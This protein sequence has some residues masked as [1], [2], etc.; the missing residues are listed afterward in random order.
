MKEMEVPVQ[1]TIR[2]VPEAG[3]HHERMIRRQAD[4][5][6]RYYERIVACHVVIAPQ[7]PGSH[8]S[9]Y[10]V[11]LR[12]E[13][14]RDEIVVTHESRDRLDLAIHDSFDAARRRLAHYA[15][16]RK[17]PRAS[18]L[19]RASPESRRRVMGSDGTM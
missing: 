19:S 6:T 12:I 18:P 10:N 3:A 7:K 1:I 16:L 2:G 14:P 11:R 9:G 15:E 8:H 4:R 17:R 13:V 5:L